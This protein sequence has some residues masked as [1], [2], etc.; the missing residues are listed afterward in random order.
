MTGYFISYSSEEGGVTNSL[1]V[2]E[3]DTNITISGLTV[4][5]AYIVNILANSSTLPSNVITSDITLGE[6]VGTCSL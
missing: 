6:P 4:G 5:A 2:E 3:N 1:S